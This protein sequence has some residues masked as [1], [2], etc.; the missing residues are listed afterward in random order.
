MDSYDIFTLF[1]IV[2]SN[3]IWVSVRYFLQTSSYKLWE[4]VDCTIETNY[5]ITFFQRRPCMYIYISKLPEISQSLIGHRCI[6]MFFYVGF[7]LELLKLR[8]TAQSSSAN[9]GFIAMSQ[10]STANIELTSPLTFSHL[11]F[12]CWYVFRLK[13]TIHTSTQGT[14][15]ATFTSMDK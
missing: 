7:A 15:G 2:V 11:H 1:L 9:Y 4:H 3:G 12:C 10:G 6:W 8:F 5:L 13:K 14:A